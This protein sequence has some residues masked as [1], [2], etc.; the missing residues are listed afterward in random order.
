MKITKR[1]LRR[2]IREAAL[3]R[4]DILDRQKHGF[5]Q[6]QRTKNNIQRA[7]QDLVDEFIVQ[8]QVPRE[9]VLDILRRA[10]EDEAQLQRDIP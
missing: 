9:L 3:D 8:Q 2:I 4:D 10:V 5:D 7:F 1:Q 6:S